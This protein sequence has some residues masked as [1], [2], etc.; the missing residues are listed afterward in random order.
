M[1]RTSWLVIASLAIGLNS[2]LLLCR[3]ETRLR[4]R[5]DPAEPP[6]YESVHS[7]VSEPPA[8]PAP[9]PA[10]AQVP[11]Q[12]EWSQVEAHRYGPCQRLYFRPFIVH[13]TRA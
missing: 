10:I 3:V 6:S 9:S 8:S 2:G 11:P 4:P 1:N 7:A 12:F 13:T 5:T